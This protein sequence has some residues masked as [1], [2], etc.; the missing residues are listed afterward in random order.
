VVVVVVVVVAVAAAAAVIVR[1]IKGAVLVCALAANAPEK[2]SSGCI[3][4][5][6]KN[7]PLNIFILLTVV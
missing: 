4:P 5:T 7:L 3:T 6:Q 1:V 2:N